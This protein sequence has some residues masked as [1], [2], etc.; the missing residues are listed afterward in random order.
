[1][2]VIVPGVS[3]EKNFKFWISLCVEMYR[4]TGILEGFVFGFRVPRGHRKT[5]ES[6]QKPPE[7]SRGSQEP[8]EAAR[9]PI[10]GH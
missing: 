7:A 9:K 3:L 5:T 6:D 8:P 2:P 1:M 10:E 4:E